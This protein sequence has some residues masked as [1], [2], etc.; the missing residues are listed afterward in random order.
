MAKGGSSTENYYDILKVPQDCTDKQIRNA[1][2]E[3]SK[4]FH[5]DVKGVKKD[6]QQT[7]HFL[8]IAEAYQTLSKPKLR[9]EYDLTLQATTPSMKVYTTGS[10]TKSEIHRPWEIRPNYDPNPGPYYGIKGLN[11]MANSKIALALIVLGIFGGV[12]GFASVKQSFALNQKRIDEVSSRAIE[13]HQ[14]IR[15]E[16]EKY[17]NDEQLRRVIDRISNQAQR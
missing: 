16:A 11:R 4:K 7:A 5:P 1:Y 14:K 13:H 6:A 3:L 17:S 8:K 12:F 2:V 9:N 10:S 15:S